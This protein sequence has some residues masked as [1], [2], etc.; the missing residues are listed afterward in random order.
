MM[1]SRMGSPLIR[2]PWQEQDNN[3]VREQN[4][5]SAIAQSDGEDV[6]NSLPL[7]DAGPLERNREPWIS[8][9]LQACL[10]SGA[11]SLFHLEIRLRI[12]VGD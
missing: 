2:Q 11:L 12:R 8:E 1:R 10:G 5:I 3:M 4:D 9:H 7:S 6:G